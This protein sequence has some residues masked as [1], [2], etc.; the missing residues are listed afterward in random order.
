MVEK[1]MYDYIELWKKSKLTKSDFCEKYSI[2]KSAF[3]YWSKKYNDRNNQEQ[4]KFLPIET[5]S[6]PASL[7]GITITYPSGTCLQLSQ[8]VSLSTIKS[9]LELG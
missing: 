2:S 6:I 7:S 9:L 1:H 4:G 8:S 3:Y 5:T